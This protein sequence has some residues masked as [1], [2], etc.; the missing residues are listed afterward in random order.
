[1][2]NNIIPFFLNIK[3][4]ESVPIT[5][6]RMSRFMI[7]L[8]EAVE[9]VWKAFGDMEG[10]EIYVKKIPSMRVVELAM[11]PQTCEF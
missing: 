4:G 7:S 10:G 9:L 8:D 3:D 6:A 2:A 1:M 11:R 5:D